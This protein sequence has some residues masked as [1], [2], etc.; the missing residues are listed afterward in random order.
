MR[1]LGVARTG[2]NS[3]CDE[4]REIFA[5]IPWEHQDDVRGDDT[6]KALPYLHVVLHELDGWLHDSRSYADQPRTAEWNSL[7]ND[8]QAAADARGSKV[9]EKTPNLSL[10]T[11]VIDGNT[12]HNLSA[13]QAA[14][15]ILK[16]AMMELGTDDCLL[17]AYDDLTQTLGRTNSTYEK[18]RERMDVLETCMRA[19]GRTVRVI[20]RTLAGIFDNWS[21][22]VDYAHYLLDGTPIDPAGRAGT[23]RLLTV[24]ERLELARR[25]I[26][27]RQPATPVVFWFAFDN[28]RFDPPVADVGHVR[29]FSGPVLIEVLESLQQETDDATRTELISGWTLPAELTAPDAR[30]SRLS[31]PD[32]DQWVAARVDLGVDDGPDVVSRARAHLTAI[33]ELA[34][35]SGRGTTSWSLMDG[36]IVY[37]DHQEAES[38]SLGP[39]DDPDNW[40]ITDDTDSSINELEPSISPR[41]ANLSELAHLASDAHLLRTNSAVDAPTALIANVRA[42]ER[43][44]TRRKTDWRSHVLQGP[45]QHRVTALARGE[46]FNAVMAY[47]SAYDRRRMPMHEQIADELR[48]RDPDGHNRVLNDF[49]RALSAAAELAP[50]LP[51]YGT[52]ERR[53]RTVATKTATPAA[54]AAWHRELE[55]RF[56][57][58]LGRLSRTRNCA[59]HGGP[60][61]E[62][63]ARAVRGFAQSI[64]TLSTR[65]ALEASL[66]GEDAA[67]AFSAWEEVV[68]A[69]LAWTPRAP[70]THDALFGNVPSKL[71]GA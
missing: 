18:V 58:E 13:R 54:L 68:M 36:Y 16:T 3:V 4:L 52:A 59:A 44:A 65:V 48:R 38:S 10:L 49:G 5:A 19:Q 1:P 23:E 64:A 30:Y 31:W 63:T 45:L 8:L 26:V 70:T 57:R 35:L 67:T 22:E 6:K 55:N 15:R 21:W 32:A 39:P 2:P 69:R 33:W 34:A 12:G 25:Y 53:L 29:F 17:A 28:A 24:R 50:T 61:H 40:V 14:I 60:L 66:N 51:R 46:L 56:R 27:H 42:L 20:A 71:S 43:I 62:P 47:V 11:L 37:R 9:A 7:A 41:L